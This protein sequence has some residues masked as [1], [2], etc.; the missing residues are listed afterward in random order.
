MYGTVERMSGDATQRVAL[1]TQHYH[2]F[3]LVNY[4]VDAA[5]GVVVSTLIECLKNLYRHKQ[6]PINT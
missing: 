5:V 6:R 4:F 1:S 2:L 3:S